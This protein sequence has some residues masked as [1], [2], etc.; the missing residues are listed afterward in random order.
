MWFNQ[1]KTAFLL[2]AMSGLLMLIGGLFGGM[3]GVIVFFVISLIMNGF[4][5]FFSDKMVLTMYK[6][7]PLDQS[8]HGW[9]Y[10][11]VSELTTTSGLP[12]PKLWMVDT[13]MANAFAT[14][15]NPKHSS[16]AVTSGI[17]SILDPQELRG[18]LAH[19]I[20]HIK[21]RDILISTV[22]ATM[23]T[24]IGFLANMMQNMAFWGTLSQ[25]SN[26][27]RSINPLVLLVVA[28][29][30]PIA[31]SLIQLAI[32]RSREYLADESGAEVSHDP[33]ALA[34]ALEKLEMRAQQTHFADNDTTH[35]TTAHL[36]IVKPFSGKGLSSLFS[37]HPPMQNRV[38][39][40]RALYEKMMNL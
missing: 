7:K 6:A 29:L 37:T 12:M 26:D 31:A 8:T 20:S 18:V 17:L 32:S 9:I 27:R 4:A 5:Y 34:S 15:R 36:F 25:S 19:E 40:L 23:A 28:I 14:G 22:A 1:V 16:V 30:M 13:P 35:A 2:G 24:A 33:L 38:A 11:I 21:N 10:D 39:R 3:S